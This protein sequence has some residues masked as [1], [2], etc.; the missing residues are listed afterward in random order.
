MSVDAH[1][2]LGGNQGDREGLLAEARR[3]IA[4][5][6]GRLLAQ[7]PLYETAPWGFDAPQRFINQAVCVRTDLSPLALLGECMNMERELGRKRPEVHRG[8]SYRTMDIDIIF[9]GSL[10]IDQPPTLIVPHLRMHL[11]RFVLQ[12]LAD[13]APSFRHPLLGLSVVELLER[14]TDDGE[15]YVCKS[16][17]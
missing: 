8:Y 12:P 3:L 4:Q 2:L 17:V 11:R 15:V 6:A 10:V 16:G 14:C 7:S 13:I 9:Y 1:L 5:R